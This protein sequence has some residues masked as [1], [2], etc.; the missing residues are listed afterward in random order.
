MS[1]SRFTTFVYP[2]RRTIQNISRTPPKITPQREQTFCRGDH[3]RRHLRFGM[4]EIDRIVFVLNQIEKVIEII[5]IVLD[6]AQLEDV[7]H[8][9]NRLVV[10]VGRVDQLGPMR[11]LRQRSGKVRCAFE[12]SFDFVDLGVVA[13]DSV[14]DI[15]QEVALDGEQSSGDFN[16]WTVVEVARKCVGF[17]G[18]RHEDNFDV[19]VLQ[20]FLLQRDQQKVRI[21]IAFM[22]FVHDN[23]GHVVQNTGGI[24]AH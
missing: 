15:L 7:V 1:I 6:P 10:H 21:L 4:L 9:Q 23:V 19:R 22:N 18:G 20:D 12:L 14:Q 5:R 3:K 2:A 17:D 13:I 16:Q 8:Q 24:L 11:I